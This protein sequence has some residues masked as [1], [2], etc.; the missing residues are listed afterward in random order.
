MEYEFNFL[1]ALLLTITIETTVLFLLFYT[2]FKSEKPVNWLLL[3]TGVIATM[4]TLPYLWFIIPLFIHAKLWYNIVCESLA[5]VVES[6]I[7]L[8]LLRIKYPKA[9]LVSLICNMASYGI[10]LLIRW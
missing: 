2:V 6:V 10:G 8:G 5:V 1:K 4:A 3:L 9:F 7:I